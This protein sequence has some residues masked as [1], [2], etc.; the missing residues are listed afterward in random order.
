MAVIVTGNSDVI[1]EISMNGS[2]VVREACDSSVL[3][4][5]RLCRSFIDSCGTAMRDYIPSSHQRAVGHPSRE[6]IAPGQ[7]ALRT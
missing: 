6:V 1:G 7:A 4:G 3:T 5:P 2:G